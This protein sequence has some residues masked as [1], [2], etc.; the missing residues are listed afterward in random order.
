MRIM[1]L[2]PCTSSC[3][4]QQDGTCTLERAASCGTLDAQPA[5]GCV[6]F[7]STGSNTHR[8]KSVPDGLD[9]GQL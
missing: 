7:I 9:H 6:H 8:Q 2:I 1:S 4:Y 3:V 5:A